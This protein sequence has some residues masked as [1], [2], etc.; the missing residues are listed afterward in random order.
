MQNAVYVQGRELAASIHAQCSAMTRRRRGERP[1]CLATCHG[2]I[3][4]DGTSSGSGDTSLQAGM[5]DR[6]AT[7]PRRF[8]S[9]MSAVGA[10][11]MGRDHKCV[12]HG[13]HLRRTDDAEVLGDRR[14]TVA[15]VE[16]DPP[17]GAVGIERRRDGAPGEL[18]RLGGDDLA[19]PT[20][21]AVGPRLPSERAA[22]SATVALTTLLRDAGLR[23]D[24]GVTAKSIRLTA[25]RDVL[26]AGGIE[27]AVRFLGN[28]SLD[29]TAAA[30]GY[31]WWGR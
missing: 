22:H 13:E 26:A 12:E 8:R 16:G 6:R 31:D 14:T 15:L 7:P 2:P 11:S 21:A 18:V 23:G 28:D 1:R 25:A 30:L 27:A 3:D 5:R 20:P 4:R 29:P 24:P 9:S 19:H 10:I 17:L